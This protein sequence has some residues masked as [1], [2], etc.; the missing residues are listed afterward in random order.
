MSIFGW[1]I[2]ISPLVTIVIILGWFVYQ[3]IISSIKGEE[4]QKKYKMGRA[5]KKLQKWDGPR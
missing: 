5:F 3:L 4:Y 2:L 1:I